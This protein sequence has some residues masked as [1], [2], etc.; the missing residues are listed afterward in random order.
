M[1]VPPN[2]P[3]LIAASEVVGDGE[4]IH[5]PLDLM[6]GAARRAMAD[7]GAP[8]TDLDAVAVIRSFADSSPLF[9]SPF[10]TSTNP[11][12]TLARRLGAAPRRLIHTEVGGDVPQ[13]LLNA[14]ARQIAGGTLDAALIAS[15][16]AMGSQARAARAGRALDWSD[17]PGGEAEGFGTDRPGVTPHEVAHGLGLPTTM[18]PLF[19]TAYAATQGRSWD[20]HRAAIGDLLSGMSVV[21]A[22]NPHAPLSAPHTPEAITEPAPDN[23]MICWPYT[24]RM[25]SNLYVDQAGAVVLASSARADAWGIPSSRRVYLHGAAD[26]AENWF[27]SEREDYAQAPAMARAIDLALGEAGVAAS[28]LSALDLYSCFPIAV[29]L[30]L[31]ALGLGDD[32]SAP[33]LTGGMPYFGGP[34]NAYALHGIAAMHRHLTRRGADDAPAFGL[35]TANGWYLT[36]HSAAVYGTA[37]VAD[38]PDRVSAAP[39]HDPRPHPPLNEAPSG[40]GVIETYTVPHERDGTRAGIVIGRTAAGGRFLARVE[41]E[42]SLDALTSSVRVGETVEVTAGEPANAARLV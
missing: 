34:G 40:R 27:V 35:V 16:E 39:Q 9:A 4:A 42:A 28:A 15:G 20:A 32:A 26:T 13:A 6:E 24:K 10:G 11:P 5:A 23:R 19:E 22:A 8:P 41:D 30:G 37:P 38:R 12:A 17:D 18:Y 1:S 25:T 21:A 14:L 31:D 2:T 36:K 7:I 3:V 33:T 29:E